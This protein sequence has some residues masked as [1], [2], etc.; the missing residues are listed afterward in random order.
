MSED[1]AGREAAPKGHLPSVEESSG[2]DGAQAPQAAEALARPGASLG[3]ALAPAG[4]VGC[5]TPL[6]CGLS[7]LRIPGPELVSDQ[8]D[9]PL[10]LQ[11]D[12]DLVHLPGARGVEAELGRQCDGARGHVGTLHPLAVLD[13]LADALPVDGARSHCS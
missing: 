12:E 7:S 5:E 9:P 8:P 4:A 1:R 2:G 10:R 13:G 6:Q 11:A 3:I